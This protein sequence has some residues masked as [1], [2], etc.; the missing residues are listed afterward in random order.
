MQ[1]RLHKFDLPLKYPF[2]IARGTTSVQ[3]TL[4]VQL[5]AN[6]HS[7]YGEATTNSYYGATYD[8]M[9]AAL[10]SV[11]PQI[12]AMTL[13]DPANLWAEMAPHF[14]ECPFALCALD[15]AAHD[16]WGKKLG[17]PVWKLWGLSVEPSLAGRGQGEVLLPPA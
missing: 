3:Q 4:I 10:D 1:L 13:S 9:V 14:A 5:S 15:E 12:E 7:G 8:R 11:R 6:G 16:L 17:A 2:T